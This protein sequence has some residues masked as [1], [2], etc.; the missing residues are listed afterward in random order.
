[1]TTRLN[2]TRTLRREV[3]SLRHGPLILTIAEE[4]VYYREKG[5]RTAFLLPHGA[6]FQYAVGLQVQR[7]RAEKSAARKTKRKSR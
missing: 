5:R 6:A 1:M 4:G 7:D 3:P 2:P